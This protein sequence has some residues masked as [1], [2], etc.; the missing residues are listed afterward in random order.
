MAAAATVT[1]LVFIGAGFVCFLN[2]ARV[3]GFGDIVLGAVLLFVGGV[4]L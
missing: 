4:L 1:A 2:A 3:G